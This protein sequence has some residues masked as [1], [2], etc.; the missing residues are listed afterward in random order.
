[1]TRQSARLSTALLGIQV[2]QNIFISLKMRKSRLSRRLENRGE[3]GSCSAELMDGLNTPYNETSVSLGNP[4]C[5]NNSVPAN[6]D[7]S[8]S[9]SRTHRTNGGQILPWDTYK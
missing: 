3:Q 9:T 6:P 7:R 1:M 5:H 2:D 4:S 8:Q